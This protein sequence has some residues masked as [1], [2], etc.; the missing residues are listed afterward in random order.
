MAAMSTIAN[1]TIYEEKEEENHDDVNNKD[2]IAD[3]DVVILEEKEK[4]VSFAA[5]PNDRLKND[6]LTNDQITNDQLT[7]DQLASFNPLGFSL[8][9]FTKSI[10]FVHIEERI[11]PILCF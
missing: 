8:E 5:A 3:P 10:G 11:Y 9:A 4:R 1:T 6:Q 7:N 2:G